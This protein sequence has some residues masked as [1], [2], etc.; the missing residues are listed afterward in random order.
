M[1]YSNALY[2]ISDWYRQLWAESLG[3]KFNRQGEAVNVGPT[4]VKA[5]GTTD[6][7]S[8]AQLYMEGP[9]DKVITLLSVD[10]F[11]NSVKIPSVDKHYLG[12]KNINELMKA[13]EDA[14]R[15]ALTKQGRPNLTISLPKISEETIGQL[16]YMLELATA[17]AG[18]LFDVNAFDQPGVELG[19]KLTYAMM[20]REGFE[21]EKKEVDEFI[22]K[23]ET[24]SHKI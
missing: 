12:N 11:N 20:G 16:I 8:Q 18:E 21:N 13:E 22:K 14:T 23:L 9:N 19:K 4:P 3:K 17:Y 24:S 10:K 15:M 5:L 1:P 7:H 6:Q 2:G